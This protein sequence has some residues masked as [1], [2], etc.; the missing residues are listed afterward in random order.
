MPIT[1]TVTCDTD[2]ELAKFLKNV[3]FGK[4]FAVKES[5]KPAAKAAD[6]TDKKEPAKRGPKP[7]AT[8]AKKAVAKKVAKAPAK[9]AVKAK[10]AKKTVAKKTDAKK[11]LAKKAT[12]KKTVAKKAAPK[13]TAV[14]KVAAPKAKTVKTA[15]KP[16]AA[17]PGRKPGIL[18]PIIETAIQEMVKKGKPFRTKDVI[19]L[20]LKKEPKLKANS[21]TTGVSKHL[22]SSTLK[23]NEVKDA[24]GRPYK[25]YTP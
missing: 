3:N 23:Y 18:T 6:K 15:K 9:K 14:K 4:N 19:T 21:V 22:S 11:P 24:V 17:R 2:Q 10:T 20:V 12:V 7:K 13:K 25:V 5:K 1:F 16:S 8:V